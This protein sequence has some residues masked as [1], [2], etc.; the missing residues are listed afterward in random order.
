MS[1]FIQT[2]QTFTAI[3]PALLLVA[4]VGLPALSVILTAVLEAV[5]HQPKCRPTYIYHDTR[6]YGR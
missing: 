4:V 5:R 1:N 2:F 6:W 3:A